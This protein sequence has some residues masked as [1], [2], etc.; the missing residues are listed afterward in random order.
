MRD[1]IDFFPVDLDLK[2]ALAIF[3]EGKYRYRLS[4]SAPQL[5]PCFKIDQAL[6]LHV[7]NSDAYMRDLLVATSTKTLVSAPIHAHGRNLDSR[8]LAAQAQSNGLLLIEGIRPITDPIQLSIIRKLDQAVVG[9]V[10]WPVSIT[11]VMAMHRWKFVSPGAQDLSPGDIPSDPPN[12]PD[13]DRNGKHFVFVHGYN[14]N[15]EQSK[16]WGAEAFK[17][18]FWSGSNARFSTFAWFGYESQTWS[19]L[20]LISGVTPNYQVNLLNCFGTA[21]SFKQYL[22]LID[23][24]TTVAAHSMGNI[25]VGS[26]MHDWGARPKNYLM[27]NSAAAKECYDGTEANDAAQDSRMVHPAWAPYGKELRASEWHKLAWLAGDIRKELTWRNRFRGVIENG[28][29]TNVFHFYSTGEEVLNNADAQNP[30]IDP[31]NPFGISDLLWTNANKTWAIQEKRKG[32]GLTGFIHTSNHGGWLPNL[33][34][35]HADLYMVATGPWGAHRMRTQAELPP[36]TDTTWLTKLKTRPFF[37]TS[38]HAD[39]FDAEEG[40]GSPGSNYPQQHRNSL[41]AAVIPCTTF[42]AGRNRFNDPETSIPLTR[43]FDMNTTMMTDATW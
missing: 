6:D 15:P 11:S 40:V 37:N 4:H 14:V 24:E 39:L 17:R 33:L 23:A 36:S 27:L 42:A 10:E 34:P 8:F 32:F 31:A 5:A 38:N 28:G 16:G 30:P 3:L 1:L 13:A 21:K 19:F 2:A 22:D 26:A 29:L 25:L 12:W 9:E 35:Y 43:H 18:M 20:P 7:A 41:L